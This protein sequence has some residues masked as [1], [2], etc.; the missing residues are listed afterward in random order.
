M[1]RRPLPAILLVL[2]IVLVAAASIVGL[3]T[4][5]PAPTGSDDLGDRA[6]FIGDSYTRGTGASSPALRWTSLVAV[7]RGWQEQNLGLGGTGYLTTAGVKG[8]GQASC[9]SYPDVVDEAV[10]AE[11]EIVVVGGGQND[12]RA[13]ESDPQAVVDAVDETYARLR[14]GL[15]EAQLI[16][17]GPSTPGRVTGTVKAM[18]AAVQKA[19]EANRVTYVSLIRPE[20][21]LSRDMVIADGVHVDDAGHRAIADRVLSVLD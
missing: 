15:P 4:S 11:P 20:P 6:V 10:A 17:V 12:F 13:F 7:A 14:R 3:N 2:V 1:S 9:P 8:C 19:A 18:D 21:V 5:R 16:A